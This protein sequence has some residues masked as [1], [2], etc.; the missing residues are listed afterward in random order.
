MEGDNNG[1]DG[2]AQVSSGGPLLGVLPEVPSPP[3]PTAKSTG[4]TTVN[5]QRHKIAVARWTLQGITSFK[6]PCLTGNRDAQQCC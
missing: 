6:E 4:D 3:P 5:A 1:V 2:G